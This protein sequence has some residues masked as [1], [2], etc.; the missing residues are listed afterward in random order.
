M[1]HLFGGAIA[2]LSA[3]FAACG[4]KVVFEE[5]GGG[6]AG[7]VSTTGSATV[8]TSVGTTTGT[9]TTTTTTTTTSSG[10]IACATPPPVGPTEFCGGSA[11]SGSG[12]FT[13]LASVC[14]QGGN[15]WE[16]ECTG[17]TCTCLFNSAEICVCVTPGDGCTGM[18]CCPPPFPDP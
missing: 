4:G 15:R 5:G 2:A 10:P 18:G 7:G 17:E 1:R 8:T 13:C 9:T 16:Q 12:S 3:L 6:G 14:D 11:G